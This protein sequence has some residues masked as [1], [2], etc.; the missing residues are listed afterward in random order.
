MVT[1]ISYGCVNMHAYMYVCIIALGD[2]IVKVTHN[3]AV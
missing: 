2:Y 3:N 1:Q